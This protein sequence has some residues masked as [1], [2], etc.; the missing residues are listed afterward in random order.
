VKFIVNIIPLVMELAGDEIKGREN[1]ASFDWRSLDL[2]LG[3]PHFH[4][5]IIISYL[6]KMIQGGANEAG[7]IFN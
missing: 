7:P 2:P 6:K 1:D 3:A 4:G 5:P